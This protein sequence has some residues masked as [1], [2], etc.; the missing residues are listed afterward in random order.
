MTLHVADEMKTPLIIA[1]EKGHKEVVE[2]LIGFNADVDVP[3][4]RNCAPLY[5]AIENNHLD[6]AEYLINHGATISIV[7]ANGWTPLL[8]A[9]ERGYVDMVSQLVAQE[10]ASMEDREVKGCSPLHIASLNN[11]ID[12][13]RTLLELGTVLK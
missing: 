10:N 12:V 4:L 11:Q 13:M 1:C 9:C 7:N 2:I 3:K 5:I 6:I 8:L